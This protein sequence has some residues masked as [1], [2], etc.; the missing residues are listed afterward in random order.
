MHNTCGRRKR[1]VG[2]GGGGGCLSA[3]LEGTRFTEEEWGVSFSQ[4][5]CMGTRFTEESV[6]V[7]VGAVFLAALLQGTRLMEEESVCGGGGGGGE[8]RIFFSQ[9]C[10]RGLG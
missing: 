10:Y 9:Y 5:C 6:G 4:H 3:L 7:G 8:E 2:R 1:E